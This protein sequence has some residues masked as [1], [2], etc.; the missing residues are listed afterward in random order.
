MC[1]D[2]DENVIFAELD[3]EKFE[4]I[5]DRLAQHF[6]NI[7]SGREGDDWIWLHVGDEKIEIDS[8]YSERLE[9]KGR[10]KDYNTVQN[11]L[12]LIE[13]EWILRRFNPPKIDLTR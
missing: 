2:Q 3:R 11:L 5:C 10:R 1:M 12:G 6:Q 9:V 13:K 4:D 7:Q 8:F